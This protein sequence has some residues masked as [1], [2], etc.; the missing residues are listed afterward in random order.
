MNRDQMEAWCALEGL[1][2][3][4]FT[5]AFSTPL[6]RFRI[7][8]VPRRQYSRMLTSDGGEWEYSDTGSGMATYDP[9]SWD[10]MPESMFS[11]LSPELLTELTKK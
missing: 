1:A 2:L 10:E 7:F 11:L 4:E 8:A 3:H 5:G 6:G 9:I